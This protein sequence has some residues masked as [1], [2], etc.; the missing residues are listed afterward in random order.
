MQEFLST[1]TAQIPVV[2]F[3]V[4][5]ALAAVLCAFLGLLYVRYGSTLSNRRAFARNF[6]LLGMTTMVIITVVKSSLALSLGLVGALSIVRFRAAI[7]E[8]EELAFL[9]LVIAVG[10]GLGADQRLITLAAVAVI[11]LAILVRSM[12]NR[13]QAI[14][15]LHV[16]I[17]TS[18][19]GEARL[20]TVV[21]TLKKHCGDLSLSR[22]DEAG[23]V[24]EA[25]FR[26]DVKDYRALETATAELRNLDHSLRVTFLDYEGLGG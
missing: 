14:R 22:F 5:L 10:L 1:Q 24:F 13:R 21:D 15:N 6:V 23:D 16:T 11:S 7:K 2:E 19:P 20:S 4:N 26:V 25:S 3:L 17:S 8:P 9:F 18:D 12:P